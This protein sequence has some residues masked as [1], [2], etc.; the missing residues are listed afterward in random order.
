MKLA[1]ILTVFCAFTLFGC[2]GD[3]YDKYIGYWE[4]NDVEHHEVLQVSRDGETY[5]MN[6]NILR[7]T[8]MFGKPK[9]AIVLKKSEGQLSVE[10]GLGSVMLG[11]SE[12]GKTLR[13]SNREF[14]K[15]TDEEVAVIRQ[16]VAKETADFEKNKSLCEAITDEY[17]AASNAI[18][19]ENLPLQDRTAKRKALQDATKE[20]AQ[21]IPNCKPGFFW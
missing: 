9:K 15:I 1:S 19:Q 14:T 12:D 11:I 10:N 7:E 8:D 16:K 17:Q 6:D 5:L 3:P 2:S 21:A 4:R 20:K 13:A 18:N